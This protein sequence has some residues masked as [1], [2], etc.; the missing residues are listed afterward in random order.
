MKKP[1]TINDAPKRCEECFTNFQKEIMVHAVEKTWKDGKYLTWGNI[2]GSSHSMSKEFQY[3]H[4]WSEEEKKQAKIGGSASLK[5]LRQNIGGDKTQELIQKD[6]LQP[7]TM[8]AADFAEEPM[9]KRVQLECK[10]IQIIEDE[11]RKYLDTGHGVPDPAH[12]GMYVKLI[13]DCMETKN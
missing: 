8:D 7:R 10:F 9:R 6:L 11:V 4:V 1:E 5:I 13:K 3:I 12:V 2:D